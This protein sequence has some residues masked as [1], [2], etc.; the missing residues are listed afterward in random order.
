MLTSAVQ[1]G[2]SFRFFGR[3]NFLTLIVCAVASGPVTLMA[4]MLWAVIS[5]PYF[6]IPTSLE[7]RDLV[8]FVLLVGLSSAYGMIG[9]LPAA[10][11][12]SALHSRLI[13]RGIDGP[14]VSAI[15]GGFLGSVFGYLVVSSI[16]YDPR[17]EVSLEIMY[18]LGLAGVLIGLLYWLLAV[19]FFRRRKPE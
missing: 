9:G 15:S 1:E 4:V 10:I 3:R 12:N 6:P 11:L 19:R 8:G 17:Y 7:A 14:F 5:D 2:G 13:R 18:P 16:D